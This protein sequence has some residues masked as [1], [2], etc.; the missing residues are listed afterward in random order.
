M[1]PIRPPADFPVPSPP[2]DL[3]NG[4]IAFWIASVGLNAVK[5]L[6]DVDREQVVETLTF[7]LTGMLTAL[8]PD[9]E[10]LLA[11]FRAHLLLA[12]HGPRWPG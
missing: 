11:K 12:R 1:K 10:K 7:S 8:E 4:G 3:D 2:R 5:Q 6:E 9:D